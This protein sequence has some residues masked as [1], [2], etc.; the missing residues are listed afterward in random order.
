[1]N[2]Q[3]VGLCPSLHCMR[4]KPYGPTLVSLYRSLQQ[5]FRRLHCC[6][7]MLSMVPL[8][9]RDLISFTRNN[10]L[11]SKKKR[12]RDDSIRMTYDVTMSWNC[13]SV[14]NTCCD[15]KKLMG[16]Q[17]TP[18]STTSQSVNITIKSLAICF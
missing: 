1:M 4:T 14:T 17:C 7:S 10:V 9:N 6:E 3:Q 15:V 16:C 12:I 11:R 18:K 13:I 5:W 2:I 8:P